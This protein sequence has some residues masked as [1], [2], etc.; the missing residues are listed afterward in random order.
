[1]KNSTATNLDVTPK[2]VNR[3]VKAFV[4]AAQDYAV[5]SPR[6]AR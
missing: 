5:F 1:M 6:A 4:P 3:V 2:R